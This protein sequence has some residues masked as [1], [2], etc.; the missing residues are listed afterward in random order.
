MLLQPFKLAK[1]MLAIALSLASVL[2]D[3]V[4]VKTQSNLR[5]SQYPSSPAS[6]SRT[7]QG[8]GQN[9]PPPL[10]RRT[11]GGGLGNQN[12]SC[13]K[14]NKP[15]RALVP[16]NIQQRLTTSKYPTFWFYIPYAPDE[17]QAI[18]FSLHNRDE[19]TIYRTSF[20]PTKTPGVIGIRLPSSEKYALK[21]GEYYHWY[22]IVKCKSD[23]SSSP[24]LS[25]DEWVQR[26]ALPVSSLNQTVNQLNPEVWYDFLTHLAELR[27]QTPEDQEIQRQWAN[28]LQSAKLEDLAEEPIVESIQLPESE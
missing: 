28:L 8:G 3:S 2:F 9:T 7:T 21:Q 4:S 22:L 1:F 6:D 25:V 10:G 18:E 26:I 5:I 17:I 27:R 24:G 19:D 15:L 12:Q 23:D 13:R 11:P 16:A 14:T 20:L